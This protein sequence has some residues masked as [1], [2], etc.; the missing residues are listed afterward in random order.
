MRQRVLC[1][2]MAALLSLLLLTACEDTPITSTDTPAADTTSVPS[3]QEI[4][5]YAG[6][7]VVFGQGSDIDEIYRFCTEL[8]TLCGTDIRLIRESEYTG[9]KGIYV[10]QTK[11]GEQAGIDIEALGPYDYAIHRINGN[12]LLCA[13][14][15][16]QTDVLIAFSANCA[17]YANAQDGC[18]LTYKETMIGLQ[19]EAWKDFVIVIPDQ[20]WTQTADKLAYSL[21]T[22]LGTRPGIVIERDFAADTASIHLGNTQAAQALALR[23]MDH[24]LLAC[25][26][27]GHPQII[28]AAASTAQANLAAESLVTLLTQLELCYPAT[29]NEQYLYAYAD[30]EYAA[31][32]INNLAAGERSTLTPEISAVYTPVGE[33]YYNHDAYLTIYRGQLYAG[34]SSGYVDE[35]APGQRIMFAR[36]VDGGTSWS[37]AAPIADTKMGNASELVYNF[38]GFHVDGENLI[39]YF[40]AFEYE[41]SVLRS[42]DRRPETDTGRGTY[43]MYYAISTDGITWSD[44]I[45][46][47]DTPVFRSFSTVLPSGRLLMPGHSSFVYSDDTSGIGALHVSSVN[48]DKAIK[49]GA[50]VL[51]EASY[52]VKPDS[53]LVMMMRSNLDQLWAAVSNTNGEHWSEAYPTQ[54]TD[55]HAKVQFGNLPNGR[56]FYVGCPDRNKQRCPLVLAISTDGENF[57][58]QYVLGASTSYRQQKTG[59]YKNGI[60]SYPSVAYDET[61]LYVIYTV[62]KEAVQVM[63]IPLSALEA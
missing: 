35:N 27:N 51:W 47:P 52:Y 20:T 63:K 39:A 36:S 26:Q 50:E 4:A 8:T 40:S 45:P 49:R 9:E 16:A 29:L 10:G 31:S 7:H 14:S 58:R 34:W 30:G 13:G 38:R 12:Y 23:P 61:H 37:D 54:F 1:A 53:S 18:L 15:Y 5:S 56:C 62:Y 21:K 55:D 44:P 42:G 24:Q 3:S 19:D 32:S 22:L 59:I 28:L 33:R 46:L 60:F 57:S 43:A 17:A 48:A 25:A 2:G 41:K 11:F 6:Y